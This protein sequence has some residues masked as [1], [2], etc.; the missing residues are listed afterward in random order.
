MISRFDRAMQRYLSGLT[1]DG[2]CLEGCSYWIYGFGYFT[3]FADM[4]RDFTG[5]E[6]DYFKLDKV[7]LVS[8]FIQKMLLCDGCAVSFADGKKD[9]SY[10]LGLVHYLK[11]Q[12]PDCVAVYDPKYAT[13][14]FDSCA[15][16]CLH[17]RS[18]TWFKKEYYDFPSPSDLE[19][20]FYGA[21]SEWMI[22]KTSSYGF[23]AKGGC[24]A[25]PHNH[26]D[27]GSFIFAKN[28]KQILADLGA[29]RYTRQYFAPETR[30]TIIENSS[31]GHSVPIIN[32]QY[33]ILGPGARA[34]DVKY[35]RGN[36]SMNI[37]SAYAQEGLARI[38][39]SFE[40]KDDSIILTDRYA[41]NGKIDI[42]E[43]LITTIKPKITRAGRIEIC[44]ADLTYDPFICDCVINEEPTTTG[45][46]CYMIDFTLKD[47]ETVFSCEIK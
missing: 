35:T 44:D 1:D 25:E 18:F 2:I 17:L 7:C 11:D 38:D 22:K 42:T 8:Q 32:G 43:R 9:Y 46:M 28:G 3:V 39:R 12:Y 15:R 16:F 29:G 6:V 37:V 24:N 47:G 26:N 30:Y 5:G 41:F 34:T 4:I 21:I 33:Q 13:V 40:L 10:H 14:S 19:G 20:E 31:R 23:A 27:V 36:F 45:K